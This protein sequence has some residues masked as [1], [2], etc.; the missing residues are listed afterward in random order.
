[1]INESFTVTPEFVELIDS[2]EDEG[3]LEELKVE[4]IA[5]EESGNKTI[6]EEEVEL[7]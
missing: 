1:M 4:I 7:E 5:K 3:A 6:T 2:A